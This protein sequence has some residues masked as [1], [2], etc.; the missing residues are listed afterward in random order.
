MFCS[1]PR[2]VC[3]ILCR[4][5]PRADLGHINF[6]LPCSEEPGHCSIVTVPV[7]ILL[8]VEC[9]STTEL[10]P[11]LQVYIHASVTTGTL[12]TVKAGKLLGLRA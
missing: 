5:E 3:K 12:T 6:V 8:F 11:A 2:Q 10:R 7:L 4:K 1:R 9:G